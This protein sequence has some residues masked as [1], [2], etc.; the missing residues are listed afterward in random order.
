MYQ[1]KYTPREEVAH[2]TGV[3]HEALRRRLHTDG[4]TRVDNEH[5]AAGG[6]LLLRIRLVLIA[7]GVVALHVAAQAELEVV[8]RP[9]EGCPKVEGVVREGAA[10][11]ELL[12]REEE[13]LLVWRGALRVLDLRGGGEGGKRV[14]D[15][16]AS[17]CGGA[18]TPIPSSNAH[19]RC[20]LGRA[21]RP[22]LLCY[23]KRAFCLTFSVVSDGSTSSVSVL[24]EGVFSMGIRLPVH[25][26]IM[27]L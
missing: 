26:A 15:S 20:L 3:R 25:L 4:A 10:V 21:Q 9:R 6:G 24:P 11:F 1:A 8:G 19:L 14:R 2:E 12:A 13:A 16:E 22:L 17:V 27:P 23:P 7:V 5:F 18:R